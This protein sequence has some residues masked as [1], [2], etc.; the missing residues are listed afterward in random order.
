MTKTKAKAKS[1]ANVKSK[2]KVKAGRKAAAKKAS[3]KPKK[4]KAS[5]VRKKLQSGRAQPQMFAALAGTVDVIG[6]ITALAAAS[7]IARYRWLD[8]NGARDRA[9]LAYIKGMALVYARVYCKLKVGDPAAVEMAKQ[10]A[11][12]AA[13]DVLAFY[14][15][16]FAAA[17]MSNNVSGS[18]T[19]RHLLVL[20]V[21]VG[22]RESSGRYC[23]GRYMHDH[24]DQADSAEAGLFQSS[25]DLNPHC[26]TILTNLF[27]DY[28]ANPSKG[29]VDIFKVGITCNAA[30]WK[31]W[32]DPSETGYKFQQLTKSCPAFAAEYA[33]VALR[34]HRTTWGSINREKVE[35]VPD[36]DTLFKDVETLMDSAPGLCAQVL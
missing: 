14:D 26:A 23:V 29:F 35:I 15:R 7:Q 34:N 25:Y 8:D 2:A 4:R 30:D 5:A 22:V 31:N 9:P 36:C 3:P 33:A 6:Q 17:G 18:D 27:N 20:L 24:F 16:H 13:R 19:L 12:D 32:G 10:K 1:K 28:A 11:A 21:G